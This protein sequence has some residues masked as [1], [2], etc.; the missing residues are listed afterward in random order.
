VA[1]DPNRPGRWLLRLLPSAMREEHGAE[2]QQVLRLQRA[3]VP[4]GRQQ[5]MRFWLAALA[6]VLRV[7]PR[8]HAEALAQD[9]RYGARSLRRA[10]G[11]TLAALITI[12][13]G[14]GA[15]SAVFAVVNAVLLRPLPYHESERL[16]LVW[17]GNPEGARTW[18]SAPELDA[19]ERRAT[20]IAAV[21][22][23]TDLHLNLTGEGAAEELS[24]VGASASLL[25]TLGVH[26]QIGR[27]FEP[28]DDRMG[29]ANVVVLSHGL[30]VRRFGGSPGV[31]GRRIVL[32]GRSYTIVAVLPSSFG[33]LPPSSV[34]PSRVDA[35]VPLQTHLGAR[36]PTLRNLHA[37][38]RLRPDA[39]FAAAEHEL[40]S[41]GAALSREYATDYRGRAWSLNLVRMQDDLVRGVRPALLVLLGTVAFVLL[42]ACANVAALLLAR[43]ESRRRE[44]AIRSALGASRARVV[45]QLLTEGLVLAL[46]GGAAGL[47]LAALAPPLTSVQ[48]LAPLPRFS[49]VSIDW[50]VLLFALG[51]ALV[52][53]LLFTVAPALEL[54]SR[55]AARAQEVLRAASRSRKAVRTGRLLAGLEIALASMV[56]VVALLLARG[57][58]RMLDA[59][60]GFSAAHVM[61]MRVSLSARYAN[62]ADVTRYFDNAIE[63]MR[64]AGEVESAAAIT[65]LP[66]S[67]ASLGS[68]FTAG[69]DASGVPV[70]ADADLRGVTA[71]YFEAMRIG[72]IEGRA[73]TPADNA[74][75]PAVA[76]IDESM[77]RRLWK[78][79][80]AVGQRIR[81]FRQP[82]RDIEIVGVV[83]SVSHRGVGQPPR[84]TVYR[85]HA[86]Y[87]RWNMFLVARTTGDPARA[88]R[89][90]AGAVQAID[91][92]QP[93]ADVMTM[94]RLMERSLAQPG[95]GAALGAALGVLALGLTA[96]GVCGLLA[97]AMSQRRREMGIRIALGAS[98]HEIVRLVMMEGALLVVCGL[99]AGLA[100]ALGLA[101]VT[102]AWLQGAAAPDTAT[103]AVAAAIVAAAALAACWI[104]ARR[105]A[106]LEPVSVLRAE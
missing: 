51:L 50:R 67:G 85:P 70:R 23:L 5:A 98:R 89:A 49:E 105:A 35:W 59:D 79:R 43:G 45:R 60:P 31:L 71:D 65:Q 6:D 56:L 18:L 7:A 13:L 19:I 3:S 64:Q 21:S 32:D 84:E 53:A 80:S 101:R 91:P 73:F 69:P 46:A 24:V 48:A 94:E 57:F 17:A 9:V 97:F 95:F 27:F 83:K 14:T 81:W 88:A 68:T 55:G 44:M 62:A 28:A 40:A 15:T 2:M 93:V 33:I 30:W 75:S 78:D 90:L 8:Q 92:D 29:A 61:T 41:I 4:P 100:G 76:V 11:F 86:Q 87:P 36:G 20:T 102:S 39:S 1:A 104:P 52:T 37:I 72:L 58:A 106:R 10:P 54:S 34:F 26:P 77:A 12:A 103:F 25:S 63:R 99:G 96:V 82:D 42:I 66:L 22:G 47:A 16:A 38:A 74:T